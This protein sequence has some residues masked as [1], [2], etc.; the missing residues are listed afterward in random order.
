[1]FRHFLME[2][3]EAYKNYCIDE[4]EIGEEALNFNCE[5]VT[6]NMAATAGPIL[7]PLQPSSVKVCV[8]INIS[9]SIA[10]GLYG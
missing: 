9:I 4:E 1:M 6:G 2:G 3:V 7:S 10:L 5:A 8:E